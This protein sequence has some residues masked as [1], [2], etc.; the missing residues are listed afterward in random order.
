MRG[1]KTPA[2]LK[3]DPGDRP[4]VKGNPGLIQ[5]IVMNLVQN[6]TD[7][8]ADREHPV[9][10][11]RHIIQGGRGVLMVTDNGAGVPPDI[12][13]A[14]FDPFF[15]TKPVDKGTGLGLSISREIA[16]EHGGDLRLCHT[17]EGPCFWLEL[18]L[19]SAP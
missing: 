13:T 19:S 7:A 6:A 1:T 17:E 12:A 18:P 8:L 4:M 10:A 16:Q 15:T 14:I 11:L 9:I 3:F 2:T 5:Q